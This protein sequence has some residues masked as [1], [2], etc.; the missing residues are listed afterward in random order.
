MARVTV[1]DCMAQLENRFALVV[2]ATKR[3]RQ[4]M[5]GAR[6]IVENT[7]NKPPV[8]ALREIATGKVR[9]DRSVHDALAGKFEKPKQGPM[10]LRAVSTTGPRNNVLTKP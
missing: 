4:L 1:E 9:F 2:L 10:I 3:S 5:A 7:K 8:L 6:P